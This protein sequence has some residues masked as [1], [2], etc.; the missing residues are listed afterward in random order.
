MSSSES[1]WKV[2]PGLAA[3]SWRLAGFSWGDD[4]PQVLLCGLQWVG[5]AGSPALG[6]DPHLL[7]SALC[8]FVG[9]LFLLVFFWITLIYPLI[10]SSKVSSMKTSLVF[11]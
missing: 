8:A 11:L 1:P 10:S 7:A 3:L 4:S 9:I 6:F 5:S 2:K